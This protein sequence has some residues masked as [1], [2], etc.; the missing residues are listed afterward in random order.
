MKYKAKMRMKKNFS[1]ESEFKTVYESI[2]SNLRPDVGQKSKNL[3][4][5]SSLKVLEFGNVLL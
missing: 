5:F 4:A 2:L 3:S 1:S